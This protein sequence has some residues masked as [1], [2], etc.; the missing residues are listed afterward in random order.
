MVSRSGVLRVMALVSLLQ[1]P[2]LLPAM[3]GTEELSAGRTF[4][5]TTSTPLFLT[6]PAAAGDYVAGRIDS[7]GTFMLDIV[8]ADGSHFRRITQ[9]AS[10]SA[11]FRYVAEEAGTRLSITPVGEVSLKVELEH[12]F[13]AQ[14]KF[15][16]ETEY[17][18]PRIA[19]L[20]AVL[21]A[22]GT[23]EAFWQDVEREGTP[24]VE[25]SAVPAAP[26]PGARQKTQPGT[27]MTFLWR[28][29]RHNVRL[30]GGPSSDHAWLQRLGESDVWYASFAVPPGTRLSYQ[31]APDIPD[32]PGNARTRRGAIGA[33]VQMDPLN[34]A[35]WPAEA[36]DRFNQEATVSLPDAPEQPGTPPAADADPAVSTFT[37]RSAALGNSREITVSHPRNLDPADPSIV[38]AVLFDGERALREIEAP[39][40]LDTLTRQGRL[41]PVVAVLVPSIDSDTRSRELPSSSVFADALADVIVPEVATRT[42]IKPDPA[43]TVVAGASYGG[44]GAAT[45]AFRRHDVFGN[46]LSMSGSFWWS[47]DGVDTDGMPY[48]A[49]LI[50]DSQKL[51]VRFFLSAGAFETGNSG[52]A[53]ILETSRQLRDTLRIRGYETFW[54]QY[55]GGH[56]Y[57][58]WRGTLAD[59]MIALFGQNQA[60]QR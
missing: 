12:V 28:G 55:S 25:E 20:A 18:S 60:G 45:V 54:K 17:L 30:F 24:L 51:P 21:A 47:P 39:R 43:R 48:V 19:A 35:P 59:G 29:A 32:V 50:A 13:D 46:V 33:T 36:P 38:V 42:G 58:I 57:F 52:V 26:R 16:Q 10:G 56:D 37:F 1:G 14:S 41:P 31:L 27:V 11:S 49:K 4:E 53:G 2:L 5:T 15:P 44:L 40:M 3:A 8:K 9:S 22:G 6:V 7:N 23:T 34:R